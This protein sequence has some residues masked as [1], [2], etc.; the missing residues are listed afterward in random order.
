MIKGFADKR[1]E[2]WRL[3]GVASILFRRT[4]VVGEALIK[5]VGQEWKRMLPRLQLKRNA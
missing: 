3:N 4:I 2:R 5:K 1:Y